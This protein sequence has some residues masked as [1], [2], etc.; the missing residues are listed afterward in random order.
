MN[1]P[2]IIDYNNITIK[3]LYTFFN[4]IYNNIGELSNSS[5]ISIDDCVSILTN[6][7]SK[8][9]GCCLIDND[10]V[11]GIFLCHY[12][13]RWFSPS[14]NGLNEMILYVK[15]EYRKGNNFLQMLLHVED[16]CRKHGFKY[17]NCGNAMRVVP[18]RYKK[19]LQRHGFT[20]QEV[21]SKKIGA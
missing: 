21:Y 1:N 12:S 5:N 16:I 19:L 2:N 15:P 11:V 4:D 17:L 13:Y 7:K 14:H 8:L 18:Q 9:Y 20:V 3:Q 10:K 6:I